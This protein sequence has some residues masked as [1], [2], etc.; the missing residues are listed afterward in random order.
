MTT[1]DV[2]ESTRLSPRSGSGSVTERPSS[3]TRETSG[4]TGATG[5]QALWA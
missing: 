5:P 1:S 3:S 2:L 4:S